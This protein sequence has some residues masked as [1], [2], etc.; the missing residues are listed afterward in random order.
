MSGLG[1]FGAFAGGVAGGYERGL[2]L[3]EK[4]DKR[5][6]EKEEKD[7]RRQ[8]MEAGA[9]ADAK[10]DGQQ[11]SVGEQPITVE[12]Q[13]AEYSGELGN[14]GLSSINYLDDKE[15]QEFSLGGVVRPA[16]LRA[17]SLKKSY[18]SKVSAS[19]NTGAM[20]SRS[21]HVGMSGVQ[22]SNGYS[23]ADFA[24]RP[25]QTLADGGLVDEVAKP[26]SYGLSSVSM[27]ADPSSLSFQTNQEA[28]QTQ[29]AQSQPAPKADFG[30][31]LSARYNAMRDKALELGRMEAAKDYHDLGFQVR[32]KMVKEGI[33]NAQRQFQLTGDIRGFVSI[34]NDAVDDGANIEGYEKTEN[35]YALRIND[36]GKVMTR[37]VSPDEIKGMVMEF[38]DP[39]H[40][41]A[42]EAEYNFKTKMETFKTDEDIRKEKAKGVTLSPG[43]KH[44]SADGNELYNPKDDS[45]LSE[46]ELAFKASQ[47]DQNATKALNLIQSHKAKIAR[48]GRAPRA[49]REIPFEQQAYQDWA[50]EPQNKGK[51]K[52]QYLREK[53]TWSQSEPLDSVTEST[54]NYDEDG[55]EKRTSRTSKVKPKQPAAKTK[56]A[57][58]NKDEL[59]KKYGIK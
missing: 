50:A 31:R 46:T 54:V 43:Q 4:I 39:A 15:P 42:L 34:Y 21:T 1:A 5:K 3:R 10:F 14:A 25:V 20:G 12:G 8:E 9:E 49:E 57:A 17:R 44:F 51:G 40:R 24:N 38:N 27:A 28:T 47:G 2:A 56:Q 55:N 30:K 13:G 11:T 23:L 48:E 59:F 45:S 52:N 29:P 16:G 35:G 58:F 19:T 6:K 7:A 37:E 32:D 53:A 18:V 26:K 36:N 22:N 33:T 41:Y